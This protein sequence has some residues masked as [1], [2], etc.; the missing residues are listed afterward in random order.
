[1]ILLLLAPCGVMA[2]ISISFNAGRGIWSMNTMKDFQEEY[3]NDFPVETKTNE[4]FPSH[5]FFEISAAQRNDRWIGGLALTNGA[6]GGRVSYNDYSGSI[7]FDQNLSFYALSAIIGRLLNKNPKNIL[8]V[9]TIRPGVMISKMAYDYREQINGAE[10][11]NMSS[12]FTGYNLTVQPT[13][14]FT[15]QFGRIGVEA[16]AAY[17]LT[18]V[19]GRLPY[20]DYED[21]PADQG[22]NYLILEGQ[23]PVKANWSG[24]RVSLGVNL[25]LGE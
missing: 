9:G 3:S 7:L 17:H 15:R 19:A 11:E 22:V 4:A 18:V 10:T 21:I 24:F 8:V 6:T 25:R 20:K 2:Q 5:W 12:E 13:F 23:I 16:Q 1:M 14:S